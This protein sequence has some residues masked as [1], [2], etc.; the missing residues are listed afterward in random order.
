MGAA[1]QQAQQ[2]RGAAPVFRPDLAVQAYQ[3]GSASRGMSGR[4][5]LAL[6]HNEQGAI[7]FR[8]AALPALG[9][10]A[11]PPPAP[12]APRG[13]GRVSGGAR[14]RRERTPVEPAVPAG[15]SP[16]EVEDAVAD[17][18]D[19]ISFVPAAPK[20][21]QVPPQQHGICRWAAGRWGRHPAPRPALPRFMR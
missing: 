4:D 15:A 3:T 10:A 17:E 19:F 5:G 2:A 18:E 9:S 8:Y 7:T 12:S 16:V 6:V 11:A 1:L 20:P 13:K 14:T 21:A